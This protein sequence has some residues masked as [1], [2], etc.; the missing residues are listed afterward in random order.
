ML[1]RKE[2]EEMS[3][4][5][6]HCTHPQI[7]STVTSSFLSLHETLLQ[8]LEIP[9]H[10]WLTMYGGVCDLIGIPYNLPTTP[11]E[12]AVVLECAFQ[13]HLA[14]GWKNFLKG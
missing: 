5:L 10:I 8:Q 3:T 1:Y 9:S 7:R 6:F 13:A 14:I 2:E 12:R 4:H 11:I